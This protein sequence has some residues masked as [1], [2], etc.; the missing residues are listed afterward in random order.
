MSGP[1]SEDLRK[2]RVYHFGVFSVDRAAGLLTRDGVRIKIQDQPFQLLL[3][4]LDRPGSIVSK[5]ELQR[6]LWA[7]DTFVEF[8]KSLGVAMVKAREAL[9]DTASNPRF[10]ETVPRKGY[11]FIAPVHIENPVT[12]TPAGPRQWNKRLAWIALAAGLLAILAAAGFW[13]AR[14]RSRIPVHAGVVIGDF[15]NETGDAVFDGSLRRA[16]I[17]DLTQSPYLNVLPDQKL[18]AALQS[19]GRSPD[20]TLAPALARQVCQHLQATALIMG[21]IRAAGRKLFRVSRCRTLP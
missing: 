4:L 2:H 21:S 17:I 10:I 3:L 15:V 5:E 12:E 18:G 20:D 6:Q 19:L 9:G 14:L 13:M 11:R 7:A 16:V 8:D 1:V